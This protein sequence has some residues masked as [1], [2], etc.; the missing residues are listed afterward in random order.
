MSLISVFTPHY[1]TNNKYIE[2][3]YQSLCAQSHTEWEWIILLNNGGIITNAMRKDTR[4]R[5]ISLSAVGR[6]AKVGF[7]K[8][9]CC[10]AAQGDILV[11]LDGDDWLEPTCLEK[12]VSA[13][14]DAD[15]CYSDT[16]RIIED[17]KSQDVYFPYWGWEVITDEHGRYNRAMPA[18]VHSLRR[19]EWSPNHV[20]AWTKSFYNKIGGYDPDLP[21]CD[22]YDLMCRTYIHGAMKHIPEPLYNQRVHGANTQLTRNAKIQE[23]TVTLWGKYSQEMLFRTYPDKTRR[24]DLGGAHNKI[25]GY[26]S[27]DL[28]G[29]DI[30]CDLNQK[31]PFPDSSIDILRA[32]DL[33]EHLRDPI[34]VMNEAYRVL[35]PG[36]FFLISVPSTDGRGAFQDPTHISFWNMNSFRYYTSKQYSKYIPAYKGRFQL[37][38][39]LD[40]IGQEKIIHTHA[41]LIALKDGYKPIGEVLI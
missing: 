21:V 2:K 33:V 35:A 20:R 30:L 6:D 7:L 32:S 41:N 25:E 8:Q 37:S 14:Q 38:R 10:Q 12:V 17:K 34:H 29:A 16:R 27:V 11:E 5:I 13:L 39:L 36:G 18:T 40:S 26:T 15:F 31:W 23:L 1:A 28:V 3:A 19:I 24:L 22:D 9:Q 4:I